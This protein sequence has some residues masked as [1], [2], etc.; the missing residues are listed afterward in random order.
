MYKNFTLSFFNYSKNKKSK[1]IPILKLKHKTLMLVKVKQK[2]NIN[3]IKK[4]LI[5]EGFKIIFLL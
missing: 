2:K 4:T 3:G 5:I 1:T